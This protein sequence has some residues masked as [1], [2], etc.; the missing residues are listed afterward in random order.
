[1]TSF[2][3][4]PSPGTAR[5]ALTAEPADYLS[6]FESSV[7]PGFAIGLHAHL[8]NGAQLDDIIADGSLPGHFHWVYARYAL[9]KVRGGETRSIV[10]DR[11]LTGG[12]YYSQPDIYRRVMIAS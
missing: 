11:L 4:T 10:E 2:N 12:G 3:G 7:M 6:L 9:G 1:M 5:V 8:K